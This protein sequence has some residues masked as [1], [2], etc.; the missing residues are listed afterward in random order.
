MATYVGTYLVVRSQDELKDDR[1][2]DDGR[3][4]GESECFVQD[5]LLHKD[6]EYEET[7]QSV[8]LKHSNSWMSS[9]K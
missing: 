1:E 2:T 3:L 5:L 4:C 9:R 8:R 6:G 7:E